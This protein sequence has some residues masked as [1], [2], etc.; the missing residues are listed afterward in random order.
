MNCPPYVE[1]GDWL[2]TKSWRSAI[3][4]KFYDAPPEEIGQQIDWHHRPDFYVGPVH[5]V[6]RG[7]YFLT[8]TV[9]HPWHPDFLVHCNVWKTASGRDRKPTQFCKIVPR[10]HWRG[11]GNTFIR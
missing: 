2:Q 4:L 3:R 6:S 7:D 5:D 10:D 1:R 8:V 9:P 11:W